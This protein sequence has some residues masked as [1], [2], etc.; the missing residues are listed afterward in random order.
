MDSL[1]LKVGNNNNNNTNNYQEALGRDQLETGTIKM[2]HLQLNYKT[3]KDNGFKLQSSA[4]L[5]TNWVTIM[6]SFQ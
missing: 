6:V 2:E 3:H 1:V 4:N 5:S